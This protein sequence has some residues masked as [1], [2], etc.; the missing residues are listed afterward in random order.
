MHYESMMDAELA[1]LAGDLHVATK[2]YEVAILLAGRRGFMNDRALA[3]ERFGEYVLSRGDTS[4]ALYHFDR[5]IQLYRDWGAHAMIKTLKAKHTELLKPPSEIK[6]LARR[7]DETSTL[8]LG[9]PS[10]QFELG[11]EAGNAGPPIAGNACS[12]RYK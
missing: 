4:D 2:H 8:S 9:G 3:H 7:G 12:I 6:L 11:V 5:A 1:A 10:G